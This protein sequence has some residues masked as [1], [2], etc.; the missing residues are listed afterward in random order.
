[1]TDPAGLDTCAAA[2]A[3]GKAEANDNTFFDTGD[4]GDT[5][6]TLPGKVN[7]GQFCAL[8]CPNRPEGT[9]PPP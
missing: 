4:V 6:N 3:G 5:F 9:P 8:P 2:L 7:A 1:M